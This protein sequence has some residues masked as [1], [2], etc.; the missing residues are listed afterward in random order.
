M[1]VGYP[2]A[3]LL[4]LYIMILL[5]KRSTETR[6]RMLESLV[7]ER[8]NELGVT[9][10][11]LQKEAQIS[12]T[13]AERS[14]LAGEIH[15]S[16]EQGLT[17]IQLQ[18]ETTANFDSCSPRVKAGLEGALSMVAFSRNEVR[19]A[20]QNLRSP[21]LDTTDLASALEHMIA[22]IAPESNH[23]RVRTIGAKRRLKPT[24]EH[25]L[26]RIAQEAI[27]NA[28]K[29]AKA[30]HIEIV[31]AYDDDRLKLAISDDGCGFEPDRFLTSSSGHFG[32]SSFRDRANAIGGSVDIIS[33][34]GAG[35][36][37]L[38]Q[39]PLNSDVV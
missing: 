9:M 31:L 29:H 22:M 11:K 24:I 10:Q 26:F 39:V 13:L 8:T 25:H 1:F 20:V 6:S 4:I 12:G 19:H 32:I 2:V 30:K 33:S 7:A 3:A 38:V 21:I 18:I 14:R 23:A 17:G 5:I 15:D 37:I 27:A 36:R 35:T 34:L 16:L 28:M